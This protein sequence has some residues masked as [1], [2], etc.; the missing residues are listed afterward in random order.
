M[1]SFNQHMKEY[2]FFLKEV[3]ELRYNFSNLWGS[4]LYETGAIVLIEPNFYSCL[5]GFL[6]EIAKLHG[7]NTLS[8]VELK[9]ALPCVELKGD[10]IYNDSIKNL[11]TTIDNFIN[12]VLKFK[13]RIYSQKLE[14]S[15]H[16][17][18]IRD[19]MGIW[20]NEFILVSKE[21]GMSGISFN[22]AI[23]RNLRKLVQAENILTQ[24]HQIITTIYE[25]NSAYLEN[26]KFF[27]EEDE[28]RF[29]LIKVEAEKFEDI[30]SLYYHYITQK[31]TNNVQDWKKLYHE[32]I[33]SNRMYDVE[34]N[35]K[36]R[37]NLKN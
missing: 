27:K 13:D 33:R 24:I 30:R 1:T 19:T 11:K 37:K 23:E 16:A 8:H 26:F 7:A 28:D 15:K 10:K 14:A 21:E 29:A 20:L 2:Q 17:N 25:D 5:K 3:E 35:E 12:Y 36:K 4:L 32:K 9:N 31:K 6:F 34:K 18:Y 22:E